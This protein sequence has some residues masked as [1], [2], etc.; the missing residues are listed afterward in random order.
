MSHSIDGGRGMRGRGRGEHEEQ[1]VSETG[2]E[3]EEVREAMRRDLLR[4]ELQ[5]KQQGE[6]W[7]QRRRQREEQR[8]QEDERRREEA[9][10]EAERGEA[11]AGGDCANAG[12][13][14]EAGGRGE[15]GHR[16]THC[17]GGCRGPWH[18]SGTPWH[19]HSRGPSL[20]PTLPRPP[21]PKE[22]LESTGKGE[23][24]DAASPRNAAP[25][26]P[27]QPMSHSQ[28][29][30]QSQPM[31]HSQP[32]PQSQPLAPW[33]LVL[34][35]GTSG[36]SPDV[37]QSAAAA[38]PVLAAQCSR[39]QGRGDRQGGLAKE[40]VPQ[41]SGGPQV[42]SRAR[43]THSGSGGTESPG[44]ARETASGVPGACHEQGGSQQAARGREQGLE[45]GGSVQG[46]EGQLPYR[47]TPVPVA[48]RLYGLS[49]WD[50][51]RQ[52]E[53]SSREGAGT[54]GTWAGTPGTAERKLLLGPVHSTP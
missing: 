29:L 7:E 51:A 35:N 17:G 54:P 19:R 4:L 33:P 45:G 8:R 32:L 43:G 24:A 49:S 11:A 27:S 30:P 13:G 20:H 15:E 44:A 2:E 10:V 31:S 18:A 6:A 25:G 12:G 22:M 36:F 23:G 53:E 14:K 46:A 42:G 3:S 52:Q 26:G 41:R 34:D 9:R 48:Q 50:G 37:R 16:G 38:G 1:R 5:V 47:K 21:R 39:E 40:R 28:P